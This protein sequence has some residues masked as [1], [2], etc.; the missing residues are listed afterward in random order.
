MKRRKSV[1]DLCL[2]GVLLFFTC[3]GIR[4][5]RCVLSTN[6]MA[7]K[8]EGVRASMMLNILRPSLLLALTG[9]DINVRRGNTPIFLCQSQNSNLSLGYSYF[10][11]RI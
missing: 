10:Q 8:K 4:D 3:F 11:I 2:A 1:C 7:D 5:R 9:A 6:N